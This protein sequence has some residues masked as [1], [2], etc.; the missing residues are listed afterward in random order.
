MSYGICQKCSG[1]L[2]GISNTISAYPCRC[3]SNYYSLDA[4]W[5]K[6]FSEL[7]ESYNQLHK[8][9]IE[10]K[11][12][13]DSAQ[14]NLRER[15]EAIQLIRETVA[16]WLKFGDFYKISDHEAWLEKAKRFLSQKIYAEVAK[17]D[18]K[19]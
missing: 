17:N 7:Q 3:G 11:T 5:A 13:S 8:E 10:L 18:P 2:W 6:C 19:A 12:E 1:V 4:H 14:Q 16:M 15:D 9:N